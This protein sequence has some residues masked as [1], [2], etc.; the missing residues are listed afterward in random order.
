MPKSLPVTL[1]CMLET[2]LTL[3]PWCLGQVFPQGMGFAPQ[4]AISISALEGL[5][6]VVGLAI[7]QPWKPAG[8]RG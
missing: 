7:P 5:G 4:T 2:I 1:D 8:K 6:S 3:L